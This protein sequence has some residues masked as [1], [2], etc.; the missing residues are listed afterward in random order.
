MTSA[1]TPFFI[2]GCPRSG[3]TLLQVLLDSHPH[4]CIPP[5]SF[6]FTRFSDIFKTYGD[7]QK[8]QN[9]EALITD[10]LSDER[11][12]EWKLKASSRDLLN[13][14]SE[15]TIKGAITALFEAYSQQEGKAFWGD[16]TPQHAFNLD[17]IKTIFPKAKI[18]HLVRDGRDV[19]ESLNRVYL[20]PKS[21]YRIAKYWNAYI[22]AF[23]KFKDNYTENDFIEIQYED[24]AVDPNSQIQRIFNFLNIDANAIN[25]Q[26]AK[27]TE[28]KAQYHGMAM[29]HQSVTEP[30]FKKKIGVFKGAFS[31]R[32]VSIFETIAGRSLQAYGYSLVSS[33]GM[34][35]SLYEQIQF[36]WQDYIIRYVRKL[37]GFK[38]FLLLLEQLRL[39]I[40]L[41]IRK[42]LRS[43]RY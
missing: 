1:Y 30:V 32:Q 26:Q 6:I 17:D 11:I 12:K 10:F 23:Q 16:K 27:N 38:S 8:T 22:T 13:T 34:E 21:I 33:K 19:A 39:A 37:F 20:G 36:F 18:I 41:Q 29:H 2:V 9:L 5:E 43:F 14:V 42:F 4:V 25:F 7:L 15:P 24:L 28:R 35:V 3:T 40:Q 31:E